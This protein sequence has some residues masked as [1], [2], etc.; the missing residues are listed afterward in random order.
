THGASGFKGVSRHGSRWRA[1]IQVNGKKISL[2]TF[3]SP[4]AAAQAYDE[5]AKRYY[6]EFAKTNAN[7][8]AL[9]S[10]GGGES[11]PGMLSPEHASQSRANTQESGRQSKRQFERRRPGGPGQER[12]SSLPGRWLVLHFSRLSCAAAAQPE[13]RWAPAQCR[14]RL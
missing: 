6:G 14:V 8:G 11:A 12:R 2:G 9:R 1:R 4:E 7:M 3:A 13:I 10:A 5:A